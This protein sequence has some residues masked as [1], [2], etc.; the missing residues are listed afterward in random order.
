M[1][2]SAAAAGPSSR[3]IDNAHLAVPSS[4]E[5]GVRPLDRRKPSLVSLRG[6]QGA[7]VGIVMREGSLRGTVA[8]AIGATQSGARRDG[9]RGRD[10]EEEDGVDPDDEEAASSDYTTDGTDIDE[11]EHHLDEVV[12][13]SS[14]FTPHSR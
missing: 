6:S 9:S 3:P 10:L 4:P 12:D 11:E 1:S 14:S 13:V 7:N 2:E 5:S 8:S